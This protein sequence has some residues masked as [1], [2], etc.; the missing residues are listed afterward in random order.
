MKMNARKNLTTSL[1]SHSTPTRSVT[2]HFTL[3]C[4]KEQHFT[5]EN[6]KMLIWL[7]NVDLTSEASDKSENIYDI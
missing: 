3:L 4:R 5:N 6:S 7:N 2:S 1:P